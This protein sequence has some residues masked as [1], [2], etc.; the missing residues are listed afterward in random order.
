MVFDGVDA[1]LRLGC[2]AGAVWLGAALTDMRP[3]L[4]GFGAAILVNA[5]LL[6]AQCAG[7]TII[8]FRHHGPAGL[9]I[10]PHSLGELAALTLVGYAAWAAASHGDRMRWALRA[11]PSLVCLGVTGSRTAILAAAAGIA[12]S[13]ERRLALLI[14]ALG[15]TAAAL[16]SLLGWRIAS[17]GHRV[18]LWLDTF[19]GVRD[20]VIT[21]LAGHGL[22]SWYGLYPLFATRNDTLFWREAHAHNDLLEL[23]FDVGLV[24][25]GLAAGFVAC[26]LRAGARVPWVGP[27]RASRLCALGI[28][29]AVL[30]EACFVFPFHMP[31]T[32]LLG[33]LA[34]GHLCRGRDGLRHRPARR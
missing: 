34:A 30:V 20:R 4:R 32:A 3:A 29:T 12:T 28:F 16:I 27:D 10:N 25:A 24:G 13:L 1:V 5:I 15:A 7:S 26:A 11:V 6:L 18:A 2:F 33:G 31:A 21:A 19:D 23:V 17:M 8:E 14:L 9:F 22:G